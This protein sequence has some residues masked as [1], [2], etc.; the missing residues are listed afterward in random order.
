MTGVLSIDRMST[1]YI[2]PAIVGILSKTPRE[3]LIEHR[4]DTPATRH[5]HCRM[6]AASSPFHRPGCPEDYA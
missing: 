4:S 5:S 6:C 3:I 1:L 2:R